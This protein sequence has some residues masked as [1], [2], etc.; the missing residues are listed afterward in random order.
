M[1]TKT[2]TETRCDRTGCKSIESWEGD[3]ISKLPGWAEIQITF[4]SE[5]PSKR[6]IVCSKC[7]KIIDPGPRKPRKD[8]GV[9]KN[10][11]IPT[12]AAGSPTKPP[13]EAQGH[14]GRKKKESI[15]EGEMTLEKAK[16]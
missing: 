5:Q 1:G 14:R 15:T 7:L 10:K 12:I 6:L 4:H 3:T 13:D 8:K 2:I 9:P 16:E 11:V